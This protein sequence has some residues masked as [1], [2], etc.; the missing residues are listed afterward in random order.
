GDN[1]CPWAAPLARRVLRQ[2]TP[3]IIGDAALDPDLEGA[4]VG[5]LR[6]ALCVPLF[7]GEGPAHGALTVVS[8]TASAFS[9]TDSRHLTALAIQAG[10]AIHNA[11][12]HSQLGRQQRLLGAVVRDINDGL[13]VVNAR[14]EIVLTNPIGRDLLARGTVSLSVKDELLTLAASMRAEQT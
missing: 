11:E 14:G 7:I 2:E 12:M 8:R 13:V 10:I 9:S 1:V 6:A 3:L 5:G 4:M